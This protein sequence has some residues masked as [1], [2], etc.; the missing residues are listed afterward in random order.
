MTG[1]AIVSAVFWAMTPLGSDTSQ[2]W[3][4]AAHVTLSFGLALL[5]T[6]LFTA[7]LAAVRPELYSHGS[8]TVGTVQQLTGAAGTAL[9]VTVMA[10][11]AASRLAGG[12]TDVAATSAGIHAAFL[13]GAVISLFAIPAAFFI[14]RTVASVVK[15]GRWSSR[16]RWSRVLRWSSL[17]R[18]VALCD[19]DELNHRWSRVLRWSSLSRPVALC[20]FD[21]LNHR[22]SVVEGAPVVEPGETGRAV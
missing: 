20:D 11:V 6:P 10:S 1:S 16:H 8:A 18:P 3:V 12:A 17:S 13:C 2:W 19:F 5:F 4:L 9:F 15:P 14:R 21:E 22:G 7:G